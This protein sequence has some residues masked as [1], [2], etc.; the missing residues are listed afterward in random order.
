[1]KKGYVKSLTNMLEMIR[2]SPPSYMQT[3]TTSRSSGRHR[4][5]PTAK[6]R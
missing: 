4:N 5:P 6:R 2:L 1:M 3:R